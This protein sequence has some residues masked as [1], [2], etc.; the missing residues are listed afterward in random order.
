MPIEIDI[1][2]NE[3]VKWGEE[4]GEAKGEAKVLVKLLQRRFGPLSE[5]MLARIGSADL[6]TLDSWVDR[7][8]SAHKLDDL[9]F[10]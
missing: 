2:E 6:D 5:S 7:F 1:R 9:F 8:D 4:L 3:L 10:G